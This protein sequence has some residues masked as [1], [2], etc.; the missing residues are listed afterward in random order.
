MATL[1]GKVGYQ[2]PAGYYQVSSRS[3][4][5]PDY[6]SG[7]FT[8]VPLRKSPLMRQCE[9]CINA[10]ID[11]AYDYIGTAYRWN[12]SMEPGVGVDCIGL[13]YQCLYATGMDLGEFNPTTTMRPALTAGLV[14]TRTICG[15]TVTC[16]TCLCRCGS[17]AT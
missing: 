5:L 17:A 10:F 2:N 3:V 12:Y 11:R 8:Y 16:S 6:A 15:T 13:V 7:Y 1:P 4:T 9:D 14:T